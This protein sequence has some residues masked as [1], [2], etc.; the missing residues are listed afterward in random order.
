MVPGKRLLKHAKIWLLTGQMFMIRAMAA[1]RIDCSVA[2]WL[3]PDILIFHGA[4]L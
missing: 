1:N 2:F 4:A 3:S